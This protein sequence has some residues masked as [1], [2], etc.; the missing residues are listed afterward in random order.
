MS[1]IH[2]VTAIS[3]RADRNLDFYTRTLGLRLVKKTVNFDDPGTYHLYY[4][5]E[6]GQPG[7]I[8]TFFPWEHAA[9]GRARR[10][11]D[12]GDRVPHSGGR[13]RLLD[14]SPDREG[15]DA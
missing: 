14:A 13:A 7:T 11:R 9:P 8:L 1:G 10:R 15:R 4:G 12:A 6:A 3:G 2:H 5:D